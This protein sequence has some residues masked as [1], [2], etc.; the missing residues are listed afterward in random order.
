MGLLPKEG[1]RRD[2]GVNFLKIYLADIIFGICWLIIGLSTISTPYHRYFQERDPSL[3][4]PLVTE[5]VPIWLLV[6]VAIIFPICII[7]LTQFLWHFT[8]KRWKT[9][10]HAN[11]TYSHFILMP[12]LTLAEGIGFT[13]LLT[14]LL[15]NFCGRLRPNF[16][17]LCNYRGYQDA[18]ASGNFTLYNSLT[19]AVVQGNLANCLETNQAIV[20]DAM[21][22]FPS[23]HSS[24]VFAGM[25]VLTLYLLH[26]IPKFFFRGSLKTDSPIRLLPIKITVMLICEGSAM[27]VAGSRTRDYYHNFDDILAGAV[28]GFC[29]S[30]FAFWINHNRMEDMNRKYN[31]DEEP[32][33]P[34]S[35]YT[36]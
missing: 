21:Y 25:T 10:D 19:T 34:V 24:T 5:S 7:V 18:L 35:I 17:A 2:L 13:L 12:Y 29:V 9:T 16:F 28:L 26:I 3:S 31:Q 6:I 14:A 8:P 22:S 32:K 30:C 11:S 33:L 1:T 4:F 36:L 15:K 27:L 20:N 23:G